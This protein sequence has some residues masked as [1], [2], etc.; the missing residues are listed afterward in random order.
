M[1]PEMS[2][3]SESA[4]VLLQSLIKEHSTL[5]TEISDITG[6]L[7]NISESIRRLKSTSSNISKLYLEFNNSKTLVSTKFTGNIFSELSKILEEWANSL[8]QDITEFDVKIECFTEYS[9]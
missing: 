3:L 7:C 4:K 2:S 5:R 1:H 9:I 8:T 6:S